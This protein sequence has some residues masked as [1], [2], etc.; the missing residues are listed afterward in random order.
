[1]PRGSAE[2]RRIRIF[3]IL[4]AFEAAAAL[5]LAVAGAA[6][7]R[8]AAPA[9]EANRA[10]AAELRLTDL[11]LWSEASYCRH[12]TQADLF[13]PHSVHP[14]APEHFPAGSFAPPRPTGAGGG[15]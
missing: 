12:L 1:M 6:G 15:P 3:L 13:A 9:R 4:L 2:G 8:A 10:L 14:A 7:H 11:A 5:A